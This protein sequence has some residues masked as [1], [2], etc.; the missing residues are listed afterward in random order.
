MTVVEGLML[1]IGLGQVV[2]L[3][4]LF[5]LIYVATK[6]FIDAKID[7]DLEQEKNRTDKGNLD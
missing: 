3:G 1:V 5:A 7:E 4:G 6:F 2:V